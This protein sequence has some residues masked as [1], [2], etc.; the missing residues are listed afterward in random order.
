VRVGIQCHVPFHAA[1]AVGAKKILVMWT[2]SAT[3][4]IVIV[5]A[6]SQVKEVLGRLV[7]DRANMTDLLMVC[8]VV[9]RGEADVL[10]VVPERKEDGAFCQSQM[11]S[12]A[13]TTRSAV[14]RRW[15]FMAK[16]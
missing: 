8:L 5:R 2:M 11:A 1:A 13:G 14:Y 7:E 9:E 12:N 16:L 6:V 10:A 15:W 4:R 3:V